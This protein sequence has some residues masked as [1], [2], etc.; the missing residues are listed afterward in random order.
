M[1]EILCIG[2]GLLKVKSLFD[3]LTGKRVALVVAGAAIQAVGICNIHAFAQVTEGGVIGATLLLDY[4]C[5]ISPAVSSF[6]LSA[7][8]YFLGWRTLGKE[9]IV[10]SV[11]ASFSY[12][13]FYALLEPFAPLWPGLV[14]S[15][16]WSALCGA[17]FVG[18]GAGLS[19]RAGG[20]LVG[21]DALAMSLSKLLRWDIQW[22]Y[23]ITDLTVLGLS[24][25]YIPWQKLIYSLLTVI[26]SG[27]IIGWVQKIGVK[28][29]ESK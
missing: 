2:K 6:V 25:T 3:C 27:Q 1:K 4:W 26:L 29:P 12:S 18:V 22:V 19:I 23:L 21:D 8:C 16:L 10:Y 17:V 15:P 14:T 5:H 24:M 11:L 28:K 9:F 13:V 7:V 20:A